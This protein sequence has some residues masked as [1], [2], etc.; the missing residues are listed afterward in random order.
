M[1][2]GNLKGGNDAAYLVKHSHNSGDLKCTVKDPVIS[3][4]KNEIKEDIFGKDYTYTYTTNNTIDK[5]D[6]WKGSISN[7]ET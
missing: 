6:E 2:T 5:I 3:V 7:S 4:A 1:T